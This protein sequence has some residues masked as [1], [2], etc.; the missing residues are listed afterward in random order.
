MI[1]IDR[2]YQ[3]RFPDRGALFLDALASTLLGILCG[4][5]FF[6]S[7]KLNVLVGP[8]AVFLASFAIQGRMRIL[9][10][11]NR[12]EIWEGQR[13]PRAANTT[14]A[15][16]IL[17]LFLGVFTAFIFLAAILDPNQVQSW[18]GPQMERYQ[19]LSSF[20]D[21]S[22]PPL[23][24][25][26][27]NNLGVLFI[28]F[29]LAIFYRAGGALL[30]ICWNASVWGAVIGTVFNRSGGPGMFGTVLI[31]LAMLPHLLLE[32][33]AYIVVSMDGIF[34][35]KAFAKY[36][37][38]SYRFISV[39]RA[40]LRLFAVSVLLVLCAALVEAHLAPAIINLFS[41]AG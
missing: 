11:Q 34:L 38:A 12:R 8:V 5:L 21:F 37:I 19:Y 36:P 4:A 16:S 2:L 32:A 28:S 31:C 15:L 27:A 41:R 24:A 7:D 40:V 14:L 23:P 26:I 9:L 6:S 29:I 13:T 10:D 18:F 20:Q 17:A 22:I 35:S 3:T 33:V 39:A 1:L 30:V 25:L